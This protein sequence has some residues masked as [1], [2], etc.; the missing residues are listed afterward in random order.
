MPCSTGSFA[1]RT[2]VKLFDYCGVSLPLVM[3]AFVAAGFAISM[4]FADMLNR[5]NIKDQARSLPLHSHAIPTSCPRHSYVMPTP[6]LRHA[7]AIPTQVGTRT[8][9]RAMSPGMVRPHCGSCCLHDRWLM[10]VVRRG[11]Q[12]EM[13]STLRVLLLARTAGCC[14]KG[15]SC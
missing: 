12:V 14:S 15:A 3:L 13:G 7:H 8:M 1:V 6:F 5:T 2:G 9:F 11:V 4:L 10:H